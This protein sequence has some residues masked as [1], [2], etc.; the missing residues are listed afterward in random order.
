MFSPQY[1]LIPIVTLP[2]I[3]EPIMF[4]IAC[5]AHY[6]T[7]DYKQKQP[8]SLTTK[9]KDTEETDNRERSKDNGNTTGAITGIGS[10]VRHCFTSCARCGQ[11]HIWCVCRPE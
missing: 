9:H 5:A 10:S 11:Y 3:P 1:I 7:K 2:S 8:V 6:M 4:D